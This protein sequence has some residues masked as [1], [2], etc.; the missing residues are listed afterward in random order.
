MLFVPQVDRKS[1]WQPGIQLTSGRVPQKTWW[2]EQ[3]SA[4]FLNEFS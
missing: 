2:S 3:G 1:N 4:I